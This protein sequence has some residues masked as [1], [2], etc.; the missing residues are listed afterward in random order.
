M[1]WLI[2][3]AAILGYSIYQA[4]NTEMLRERLNQNPA[5]RSLT[6]THRTTSYSHIYSNIQQ[7]VT[8]RHTITAAMTNPLGTFSV[9]GH[10]LKAHFRLQRPASYSSPFISIRKCKHN[11]FWEMPT[12][13]LM[14]GHH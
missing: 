12:A 3:A 4:K 6:I 5:R 10:F 11:A 1:F 9:K 13:V 7:P 8:H 2:G 14:K